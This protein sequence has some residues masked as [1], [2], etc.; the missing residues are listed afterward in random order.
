MSYIGFGRADWCPNCGA[1][2]KN[3]DEEGVRICLSC[4]AHHQRD[5][6]GRLVEPKMDVEADE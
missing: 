4:G 3:A 5:A 2:T 1:E 6:A